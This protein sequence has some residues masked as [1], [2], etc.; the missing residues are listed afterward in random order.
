MIGKE[1]VKLLINRIE[2][3]QNLPFRT[4]TI[5]TEMVIKGS[6]RNVG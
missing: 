6:S 5:K 2:K 4:I 1:A 3:K